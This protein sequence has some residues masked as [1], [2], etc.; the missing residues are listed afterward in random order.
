MLINLENV[1]KKFGA[2][3]LFKDI[4]FTLNEKEK[5]E[6]LINLGNM[7]SLGYLITTEEPHSF[8]NPVNGVT[9]YYGRDRG[10]QEEEAEIVSLEEWIEN[11]TWI[12][13]YYLFSDDEWKVF[14]HG[15]RTP[16]SH[17]TID[18]ATQIESLGA[19][20]ILL[21]SMNN[22]GTKNGFALDI[23]SHVSET[24]NIPV[25]A[26]GGAGCPEHFKN[27]FT[28]TGATGGLAAS[29]FHYGELPIPE[30]KDYLNKQKIAV[31]R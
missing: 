6:E 15:G 20:E 29:I 21:T 4:N 27:V 2:K 30:L 23:T 13:Y 26:S 25:I 11:T 18:W 31:R 28:Q 10:D 3:T 12:D 14:I 1:S 17:K 24:V 19:G 16:T 22:D 7:S 8:N 9:V 5:V